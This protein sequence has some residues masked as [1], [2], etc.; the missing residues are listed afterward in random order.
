MVPAAAT[1]FFLYIVKE[2]RMYLFS[3]KVSSGIWGQMEGWCGYGF[4]LSA[5]SRWLELLG[6]PMLGSVSTRWGQ[7]GRKIKTRL[8]KNQTELNR[9]VYCISSNSAIWQSLLITSII[10]V[11]EMKRKAFI[12]AVLWAKRGLQL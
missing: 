5:V 3:W 8:N 7:K 6:V 12:R 1:S 9:A 11:I 2:V 4:W 10:Q